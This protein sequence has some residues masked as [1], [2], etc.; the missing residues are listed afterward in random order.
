MRK[1]DIHFDCEQ[2][3]VSVYQIKMKFVKFCGY[4]TFVRSNRIY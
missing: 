2:E 4:I 1:G 3:L